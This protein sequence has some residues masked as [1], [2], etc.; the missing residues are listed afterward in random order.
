MPWDERTPMDQR[1]RFIGALKSCAY[2]MTLLPARNKRV[3]VYYQ[4]IAAL[5]QAVAHPEGRG[6]DERETLTCVWPVR[7]GQ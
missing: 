4:K 3:L 5:S 2:T 6:V 7:G 1:V